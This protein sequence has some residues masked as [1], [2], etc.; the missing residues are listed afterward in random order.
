MIRFRLFGIPFEIG[1]YFWIGAAILGSTSATGQNAILKLAVWVACVL[2]SI[3]VHELG[4]AFAARRFGIRPAVVLHG[5]GGL[6]YLPGARLSRG[7]SIF[8]SLAGPAAGV[9]LWAVTRYLLEPLAFGEGSFGGREN[10]ATYAFALA[11]LD[12]LFMN[13]YWTIF[14]LLPILPLDGGQVLRELLGYS[15]M[16]VTRAIGAS[17]AAGLAV[18]EGMQGQIYLAIFLGYLA[19]VNYRGGTSAIP[20]GVQRG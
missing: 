13:L 10:L 18:Y 16:Q 15:R 20:G 2:V 12:L 3:V 1:V 8:V 5:I 6:T 14:N 11:V 9:G 17:C 7:Q 4:H 19:F